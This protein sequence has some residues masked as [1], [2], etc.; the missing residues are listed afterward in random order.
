MHTPELVVRGR[1]VVTEKEIGPASVH[2]TRGYISSI[3]IFEDVPSGCELIEAEPDSIV[4]P[5]L[6]DTHVH[7]N[8]PGRT[9]WEGFATATRA[10][11]AGGV[12]TIVDMPLNSIP[13]TTTLAGLKEKLEAASGKCLVDVGFW[14][15]V[16]P[17]NTSELA[18]LWDAGVVGFKCFLVHSGVDEFPN[19]TE[20]DLR[21]AMPELARLGATLIVHAE[22][23]GPIEAGCGPS[24]TDN[25]GS[26]AYETF[27]RSRPREA[28]NETVALMIR[29]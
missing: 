12:T 28:E 3:S 9:D 4:M 17:G 24:S 10:A 21:E 23:P 20:K 29:L 27:F 11:A 16:V 8:E 7:L 5:G 14:G 26:R 1:R 6:V 22:L 19:V 13:A 18:K 2:V 25:A 15:G